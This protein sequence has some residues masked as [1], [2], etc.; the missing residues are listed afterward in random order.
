[1]IMQVLHVFYWMFIL[2]V[3]GT[4][5]LWMIFAFW[6]KRLNEG[7]HVW[8]A[9]WKPLAI[10][11]I[12]VGLLVV[13]PMIDQLSGWASFNHCIRRTVSCSILWGSTSLVDL[14]G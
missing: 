14:C 9:T 6:R 5:F 3:V 8:F 10:V 4:L 12:V 2:E 1:M 7:K 13:Q 11:A